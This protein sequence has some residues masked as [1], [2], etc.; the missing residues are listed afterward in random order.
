LN[1]Y[2]IFGGNILRKS[3]PAAA[4]LQEADEQRRRRAR[5]NGLTI[6]LAAVLSIGAGLE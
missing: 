1:L 5:E 4:G 3:P 6:P 2:A